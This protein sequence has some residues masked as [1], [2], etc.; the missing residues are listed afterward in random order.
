[1]LNSILKW[2]ACAVTLAGALATSLQID[3]LN[4]YLLNVG[5]ILYLIWSVRI[6]EPS[7]VVINAGLLLI[8]LVGVLHR[9]I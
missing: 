9:H 4:I 1:M 7:L 3:P 5:S 6:K 8:Y 2:T